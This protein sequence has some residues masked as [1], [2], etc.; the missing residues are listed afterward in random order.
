MVEKFDGTEHRHYVRLKNEIPLRFRVLLDNKTDSP[1]DWIE[2]KT[3]NISLGGMCI[4]VII[5]DEIKKILLS[6]KNLVEIEMNL[7][8]ENKIKFN[9][10]TTYIK[11]IGRIK[12]DHNFSEI[13]EMGIQFLDTSPLTIDRI[14]EF[15]TQRYLDKYT[16]GK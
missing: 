13:Y 4:N 7:T 15:I 16:T 12:W 3:Q 14:R 6:G 1:T 8:S 9:A 5:S 11:V 2:A 10:E